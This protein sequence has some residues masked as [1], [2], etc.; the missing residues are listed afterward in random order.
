MKTIAVRWFANFINRIGNRNWH[1]VLTH[2]FQ[3]RY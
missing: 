3:L 2:I 1:D